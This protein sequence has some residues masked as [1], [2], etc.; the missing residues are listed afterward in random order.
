MTA[1]DTQIDRNVLC[2]TCYKGRMHPKRV[3]ERFPYELDGET[4]EVVAENVPVEVFDNCGEQLSGPEAAR[5]R[6]E[7]ICR[8]LGLLTPA[9]IRSIRERLGMTQEQFNKLT[10]I[11]EATICRWERGRLLQ[12]AAMDRY[13]RL[14]ASGEENVRF[15]QRLLRSESNGNG[16]P[17]TLAIPRQEAGQPRTYLGVEPT[18]DPPMNKTVTRDRLVAVVRTLVA[19]P[20]VRAKLEE[21]KKGASDLARP[22]FIWHFFLQSMA[23]MRGVAGWRGLIGDQANYRRVTFSALAALTEKARQAQI[24]G[25]CQDAAREGLRYPNN[26]A[27]YIFQCFAHVNRLGGP[28]AAKAKLLALPGREPK[29]KFLD[30][31]PGIGP[32]YARNI[33]MDVYHEDFRYSIALDDRLIGITEDLGLSFASYAEHEAFYLD[34]AR[35]VGLNGWEL[36]RLLFNFEDEV[37]SRLGIPP[38]RKSRP[39]QTV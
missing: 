36:D 26:K 31:F 9:E 17:D 38:K 1:P 5:I 29:L 13:L 20:N 22:D 3:A 6:H 12:N 10:R 2:P 16:A 4:A 11:G 25:V 24:E 37:R 21:L 15:L 7:A 18:G 35:Q 23:T 27:K 14:I 19:D 33:M 32:K 39:K 30:A 28:E 34:V 8:A